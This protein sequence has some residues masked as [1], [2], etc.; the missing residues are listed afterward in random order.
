MLTLFAVPKPFRGHVG[1][2][3]RNA[4][5]SWTLLRPCP[6]IILFGDDEGTAQISQELGL[7]HAPSVARNEFG[8]PLL[9]D[10]FQKAEE[11]ASHSILCY[12]NADILLL[13]DFSKA[14]ARVRDWR[15]QFLMVGQRWDVDVEAPLDF[16]T[17]DWRTDLRQSVLRANRQRQAD[18][19]DYFVF[20]KGLGSNL[21]PFAIGRTAWDNWLVWHARSQGAPVLNA[22]K[23]VMAVHQNH[24]YA[25]HPHGHAGVWKGEEA[26]RNVSLGGGWK[27]HYTI[28]DSQFELSDLEIRRIWRWLLPP[29]RRTR[30]RT[31]EFIYTR[32][33]FAF[34]EVTRRA[35]HAV[36][37]R[38]KNIAELRSKIG[39]G[40]SA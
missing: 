4:I 10:L 13:D 36:G 15:P 22:S 37:L 29:V 11:C 16:S 21:L 34:L 7:L 25:H 14:V 18:W 12:V 35:R 3:Q 23:T 20:T 1:V 19:I 32:I 2:I 30:R 33:W 9:R 17:P 28:E 31:V 8:T 40:K 27:H 5:T 6:E 38:Q 39:L 24:D 26:T